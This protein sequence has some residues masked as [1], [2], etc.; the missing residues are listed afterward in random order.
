MGINVHQTG[1]P[2]LLDF[3]FIF[4][5]IDRDENK[6]KKP[7]VVYM[8]GQRARERLLSQVQSF[9]GPPGP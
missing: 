9:P 2:S 5:Y 7:F 1:F 4:V 6:T 3:R 8:P